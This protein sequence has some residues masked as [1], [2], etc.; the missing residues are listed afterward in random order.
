[1]LDLL[2]E[3]SNK[4]EVVGMAQQI[5]LDDLNSDR[6]VEILSWA[7]TTEGSSVDRM[8]KQDEFVVGIDYRVI[9]SQMDLFY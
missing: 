9:V 5:D 2:L 4:G 8:P 3:C 6:L 1:M 7:D